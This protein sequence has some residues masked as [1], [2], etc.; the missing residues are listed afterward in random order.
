MFA[1]PLTPRCTCC[2]SERKR[3]SRWWQSKQTA[4]F[5]GGRATAE[6]SVANN[7]RSPKQMSAVLT[8]A[9]NE[10]DT[11]DPNPVQTTRNKS[12]F[13][14]LFIL[15]TSSPYGCELD[16]NKFE[17]L[18]RISASLLS[19]CFT[20]SFQYRLNYFLI[21]LGF[22]FKIYLQNGGYQTGIDHW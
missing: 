4:N 17:L 1:C 20:A 16:R 9:R 6:F 21:F 11:T 7:W 3:K 13:F 18:L 8:C 10:R 12:Q 2:R 15:F 22:A 14:G 19:I 5:V